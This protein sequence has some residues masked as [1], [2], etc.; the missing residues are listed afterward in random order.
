MATIGRSAIAERGAGPGDERGGDR[1]GDHSSDRGGDASGAGTTGIRRR[2][3]SSAFSV[4]LDI[5]E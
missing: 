4:I 2:W 5:S 3:T 1:G